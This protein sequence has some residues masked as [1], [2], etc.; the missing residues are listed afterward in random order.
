MLSVTIKSITLN[1]GTLRVVM[2][3]V[4]APIYS[5]A[6]QGS[7]HTLDG[8]TNYKYKLLHFL[9]TKYFLQ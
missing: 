6:P 8:I 3:N 1:F 4:V 5:I 7:Y 9:T 2:L